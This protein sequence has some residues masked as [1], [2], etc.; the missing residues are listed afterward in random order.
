MKIGELD[1]KPITENL[2]L[3]AEPIQNEVKIGSLGSG[4][5]VVSIDPELADTATFCETY[6]VPR[7]IA[8]NCIIV[9]AKRAD[10]V[11]YAAC[12]ILA[13]DMIDVNGKVRKHLE[14][15]KT[16]FAP[17]GIALE[18][19]RMEYGGITPLGLP[20]EWSILIDKNVMTN[21]YA[22][23]GGGIRGSKILADTGVLAALDHAEIID[24]TK[25]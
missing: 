15:R 17:K 3:V 13:D 16:S 22:V 23:I 1:F 18:L 9:E 8:A 4:I 20:K 2:N 7:V 10:K 12:L 21:E 19:T 6:N 11:W 14:A 24:I 25:S 5:N